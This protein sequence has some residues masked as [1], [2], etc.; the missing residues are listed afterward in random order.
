MLIDLRCFLQLVDVA[1][2]CSRLEE[3]VYA[4][5]LGKNYEQYFRIKI[6]SAYS[7]VTTQQLVYG[8]CLSIHSTFEIC[9]GNLSKQNR[10]V[11][12]FLGEDCICMELSGSISI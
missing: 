2:A 7:R 8:L 3:D 5:C 6:R 11:Q 12:N 4:T 10:V 1:H 9:I